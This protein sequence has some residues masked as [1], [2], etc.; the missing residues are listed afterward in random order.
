MENKREVREFLEWFNGFFAYSLSKKVT[1]AAFNKYLAA[2]AN[3][4]CLSPQET[5]TF[6]AR[7][8]ARE[9]Y[10]YV[11]HMQSFFRK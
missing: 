11:K 7:L 9:D 2:I 3:N 6:R 4:H 8:L 1:P 5:E 10:V